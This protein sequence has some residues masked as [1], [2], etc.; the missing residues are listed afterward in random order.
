METGG[1][2]RK[3]GINNGKDTMKG[4]FRTGR[5]NRQDGTGK[6]TPVASVLDEDYSQLTPLNGVAVQ[7]RQSTSAGTVSILC[8]PDEPVWLLC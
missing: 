3:S 6:R 1:L 5:Q 4:G 7:A 2:Y 8:S